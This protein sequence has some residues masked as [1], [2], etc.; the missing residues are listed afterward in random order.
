MR[1]IIASLFLLIFSFQL[2]PIKEIGR[3]LW[4]GNMTEEVNEQGPHAKKSAETFSDKNWYQHFLN[5]LSTGS[6]NNADFS[7]ALRDEALIPNVSLE[8]PLQPPN[9]V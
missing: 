6:K 5:A 9:K 2:L 4:N 7:H 8:V 1:P 3:I